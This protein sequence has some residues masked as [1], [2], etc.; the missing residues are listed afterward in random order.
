MEIVTETRKFDQA[1]YKYRYKLQFLRTI[2]G[3][4]SEPYA[5]KDQGERACKK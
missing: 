2:G 5:F 3:T 1:R 4:P